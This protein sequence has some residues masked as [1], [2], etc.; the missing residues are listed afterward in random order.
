MNESPTVLITGA[1]AGIGA[2]YADRFARRG[3]DLVL[4]ARNEA[5]L[6][7]LAERLRAEHGIEVELL[8]ADLTEQAHLDNV[9]QRLRVD[10]RIGILI[11]N[12]G[13]A[14]SGG[15][16]EQN[17]QSLTKLIGL[18]VTAMTCL[19]A[20]AAS[21]FA[22]SGGGQIVNIGSLVGLAPE[23]RMTAY[24]ATKAYVLFL[25]QGMH[26]ELS[27]KGVYVQAVLPA[28][29]RTDIWNSAGLSELPDMMEVD[30]L[31]DAALQGFDRRELIT[32]P[33]LH[34]E[35]SWERLELA[36]KALLGEVRQSEVAARYRAD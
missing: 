16:L 12:A 30:A 5:R 6:E 11:N 13:M 28:A 15:F 7:R 24:G 35:D 26:L 18:N 27:A 25:S 34:D 2:T 29:T 31:V 3:H 17:A 23:L 32:L 1:S 19:A 8:P 20:A 4:V 33:A 22:A 10:R 21:R 9:Q 14:Q 36:R